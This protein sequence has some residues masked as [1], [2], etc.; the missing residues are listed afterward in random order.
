MKFRI[1]IEQCVNDAKAV[2]READSLD[3]L[4]DL[5]LPG[6]FVFSAPSSSRLVV[7]SLEELH[8]ARA[9]L[10]REFGWKDKIQNKF[11]SSG[12]V[13]VTYAPDEEVVLP[14]RFALWVESPPQSFPPELLGNCI[15]EECDNTEYRIVCSAPSEV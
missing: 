6:E 12:V 13:I 7:K 10:R 4:T 1:S 9:V 3:L 14:L 5:D 8:I 15:V 2:I 11:F